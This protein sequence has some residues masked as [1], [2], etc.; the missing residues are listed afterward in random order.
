M[1]FSDCDLYYIARRI[2]RTEEGEKLPLAD[3]YQLRERQTQY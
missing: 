2:V 1:C 3:M